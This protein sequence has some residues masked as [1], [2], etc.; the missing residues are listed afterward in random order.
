[1]KQC[2]RCK[3]ILPLDSFSK[4]R[5]VEGGLSRRCKLCC[6]ALNKVAR[7]KRKTKPKILV[8]ATKKCNHCGDFLPFADFHRNLDTR[9]GFDKICRRCKA[10]K[11]R[12]RTLSL[13]EEQRK[14]LRDRGR[15]RARTEP[16]RARTRERRFQRLYGVTTDWVSETRTKQGGACAICRTRPSESHGISGLHLDH[17]HSTNKVRGLLCSLCNKGLG[18]FKDSIDLLLSAGAYLEQ[19]QKS[20]E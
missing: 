12:A 7:E 5:A 11:G 14:R 13:T 10:E 15:E 9:D 1:M 4:E 3:N 6:M 16:Y 19:Y 20:N 17:C 18:S 2:C 8:G